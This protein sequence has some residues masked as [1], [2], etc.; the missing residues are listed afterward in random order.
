MS[1]YQIGNILKEARNNAYIYEDIKK[2]IKYNDIQKEELYKKAREIRNKYFGN[3]LFVRASME[4][5]NICSNECKYCGMTMKNEKL[6]RYTIPNKV[7]KEGILHIKELGIKQLHLVSGENSDLDVD[8]FCEVIRFARDNDI[9]TTLVLGQKNK[10]DYQKFYDAGARRYIIKFE[11]SNPKLFNE[12]KNSSL[13]DRVEQLYI[14]RDIGFKVGTGIIYDL[15][16]STIEDAINDLSL[17]NTIKPDMASASAFS[18]NAESELADYKHGDVDKTL[19]FIAYLRII[20]DKYTPTISCSS[21]LGTEGQCK[22]LMAGAN[23]ISY[24]IT[25]KEYIDGFSIYKS[26]NRIKTKMEAIKEVA[27]KC[28]ME[29]S[30]YI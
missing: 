12:Y 17:L 11:T 13:E 23:V 19:I 30:E 22:A 27:K 25:P 18:P 3:K 4:F 28:N 24:H 8:E 10:E 26:S 29:I 21:S 20:L 14:L 6:K 16:N 9:N 2:Y 7:I 15:P 5:S 1:N